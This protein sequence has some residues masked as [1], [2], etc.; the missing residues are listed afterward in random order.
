MQQNVV[1]RKAVCVEE[2]D[3]TPSQWDYL[4]SLQT[5]EVQQYNTRSTAPLQ[6]FLD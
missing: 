2:W 4:L 6:S 3:P 1:T 5:P